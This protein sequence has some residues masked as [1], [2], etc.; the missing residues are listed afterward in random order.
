M[1]I[2]C[3]LGGFHF[4]MSFLGSIG[5]LMGGSG[6][7]DM[8]EQIFAPNVIPHILS[9]KA[10]ARSLRGHLLASGALLKSILDELLSSGMLSNEDIAKV[11]T[12]SSQGDSDMLR[13]NV[14]KINSAIQVWKESISDCRTANFWLQYL[15]YIDIVKDYIRAEWTS[16]WNLH[17]SSVG[18]MLNPFAATGHI[19][20]SMSGRFYLQQIAELSQTHPELYYQFSVAGN[21]AIHRSDRQW[22]GLWSDLVIEQVMMRSIKSNGG[23]TRGRGFS[24]TTRNQWILTA[25][26]SASIH[27]AMSNLTKAQHSSSDQHIDTS[28]ARVARD[29]SDFNKLLDWLNDHNPFDRSEKR[30]KSL[31][32]GIIADKEL[33]CE[34][35]ETVGNTIQEQLDNMKLCEVKIKRKDMVQCLDSNINKVTVDTKSVNINQTVLFTRLTALA[36]RNEDPLQ[37][38]DYELT[39]Y[40]MSLFKDGVM[41]KADKAALRNKILSKET[42]T[43]GIEKR[44]V[45]GGAFLHKV[46]WPQNATYGEVLSLYVKAARKHYGNCHVVFDGYDKA[47]IKDSEHER[48]GSKLKQLE[49][50][51]SDDMKVSLKREE[52]LSNS[53]N[54]SNLIRKLAPLLESDPQLVTMSTSDADTDIVKVA[55][56]V[57]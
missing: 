32:T 49:V 3:R 8:L 47:S 54:K 1:N 16:I 43:D 46:F 14:E 33:S 6:L 34:K 37:N 15:E 35:A 45:D 36:G 21:H 17:L 42:S 56:Q 40:P 51:F 10:Y 18:E 39:T 27:E 48:R 38:F 9:G 19:Y 28:D 53:K 44:I 4:L 30:L 31:S 57:V 23:L 41:R 24:E 29:D 25:H 55:L 13:C 5:H 50:Q 7:E 26:Q 12:H 22:A 11:A 52:F 20:Y 2:V